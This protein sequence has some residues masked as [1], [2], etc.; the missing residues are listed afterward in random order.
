[1][2][3]IL[4][5]FPSPTST[6]PQQIPA[7]SIFYPGAALEREGHNVLY[8]DERWDNDRDLS[9]KIDKVDYVG[10]SSLTGE[11]LKGVKRILT[12]AKERGKGQIK[13]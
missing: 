4:L 13:L 3:D 2:S 12:I 9:D 7:L 10:T 5:T 11:Q 1:M 6:S 8:W